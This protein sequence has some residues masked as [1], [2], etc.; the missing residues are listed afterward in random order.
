M[1]DAERPLLLQVKDNKGDTL[2]YPKV[3]QSLPF[4]DTANTYFFD[5]DYLVNCNG[6]FTDQSGG[7]VG[8][9]LLKC[10]KSLG[11]RSLTGIDRTAVPVPWQH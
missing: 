4:W 6:E 8:R 10:P 2:E 3:V 5:D 7:K 9:P 1:D 11:K